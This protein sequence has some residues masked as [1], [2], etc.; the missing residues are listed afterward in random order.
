MR[1]DRK[2]KILETTN[3]WDRNT[4]DYIDVNNVIFDG[5]CSIGEEDDATIDLLLGSLKKK[6]FGVV[7]RNHIDLDGYRDKELFCIVD[8]DEEKK[9]TLTRFNYARRETYLQITEL[10]YGYKIQGR[11]N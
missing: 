5:Y 11:Y 7:I 8:D 2:I 9:Y 6:M 10:W 3:V 1:Y 4:G